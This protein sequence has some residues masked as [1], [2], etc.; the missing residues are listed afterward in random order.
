MTTRRSPFHDLRPR[1]FDFIPGYSLSHLRQD[2]ISGLTV[3]IVALPLALAFA[4]ASG[5]APERGLFTAI[6]AGFFISFLGGSRHQIGGPTGA[7]VAV[8]F[9]VVEK[10]GYDGLVLATL[11]AGLMLI[12]LGLARLGA[13]I[14]FIPYPVIAGFTTGIGVI[15]FSTQIRDFLG[16]NMDKVPGDFIARMQAYIAAGPTM[17]TSAVAIGLMTVAII[18]TI[19]KKLPRMP[20]AIVGVVVASAAVALLNLPVETIGSRFGGLPSAIPTPQLPVFSLEKIQTVFPDAITIAL[21]AAIESLLS[22]M[23]ADGMTGERHKSNT[24]LIGQGVANIT[25]VLFGGIAATGAIAR[26]AVN[27]RSGAY[28]P[29]SGMLHALFLL[30]FVLCLSPLASAIPLAALA[31]VL[32]IAAYD[33]ADF[34]LFRRLMRAP[35]SDVLVLVTTFTLTVLVDITVAVQ[36]GV[37]LAALLF[38]KRMSD[39]VGIELGMGDE[40]TLH[41]GQTKAATPHVPAGVEIYKVGGPFFFGAADKMAEA[42]GRTGGKPKVLILRIKSA[43]FID[44]TGIHA[45][46][47]ILHR[48]QKQGTVLKLAGVQPAVHK[49]LDKMGFTTELGGENLHSSTADALKA[50]KKLLA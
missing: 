10:H 23:I 42:V 18:L 46:E 45:L 22:A 36:V 41:E 38:I 49:A 48:C 15:I 3:A 14:K 8:L 40:D 20:A 1:L 32:F 28:S 44:A 11:L 26:T 17:N 13:F 2:A 34:H 33:M 43:P 6:V 37:A 30:L 12:G 31:G 50:A 16:L 4:I 27:V 19:R 9:L 47:E 39:V 5:V 21:L 7:F 25:S 24:E 29:V 35:G